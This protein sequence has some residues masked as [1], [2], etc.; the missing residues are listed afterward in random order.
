MKNNYKKLNKKVILTLVASAFLFIALA[1][2]LPYGYFT[3]LRFIV[4]AIT[5]YLAYLAYE[6]NN[7]SFW[8]W[9]FGFIAVLFNPIFL[10]HL[11]REVWFP[12]DL[13]TGIFLLVTIFIFK[14]KEKSEN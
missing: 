8:V 9:I 14:S 7:E 5:A 4:C 11:N 13:I 1:N 3:L 10:I 6:E 2:G 12:I